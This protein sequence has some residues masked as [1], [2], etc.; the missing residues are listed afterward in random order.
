MNLTDQHIL[1]VDDD[2]ATRDSVRLMIDRL[3][4][5][6]TTVDNGKDA[7]KNWSNSLL[8]CSCRISICP[9]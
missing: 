3:G 6:V 4:Y 1:V 9:G 5:Q 7:L 2:D 8:I